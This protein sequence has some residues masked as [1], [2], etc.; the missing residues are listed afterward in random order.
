MMTLLLIRH[1]QSESPANVIAGRQPNIPLSALGQIQA[2]TLASGLATLAIGAIYSSPLERAIE[3]ARQIAQLFLLKIEITDAFN[4][5]DYGEWTGHNYED[6][7][8]DPTWVA[9]NVLRSVTRIPQGESIVDVER[10]AITDIE[11]MRQRH[12]NQLVAVV[13]HADVIRTVLA[14]CLG[15]AFDLAARLEISLASVSV[16]RLD[17]GAPR[18]LLING[19]GFQMTYAS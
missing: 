13:T 5:L 10:R 2:E 17:E 12:R 16:I 8:H 9:Y 3:T 19:S 14:H 6:L 4:E 15:L 1:A 18:I 11:R 7:D